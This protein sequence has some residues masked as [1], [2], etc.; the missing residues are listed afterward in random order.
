M[1]RFIALTLLLA[2]AANGGCATIL[3]GTKQPVRIECPAPGASIEVDGLPLDGKNAIELERGE[4]HVVIASAP[5]IGRTRHTIES[6]ANPKWVAID[7]IIAVLVP[8]GSIGLVVDYLNGAL[9]D[10]APDTLKVA[11]APLSTSPK[12]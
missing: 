2:L 6:E 3:R 10:L 5:K 8:L 11:L 1:R 12:E 4:G 7:V 9:A